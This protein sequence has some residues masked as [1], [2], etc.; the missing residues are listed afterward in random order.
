MQHHT[1]RLEGRKSFGSSFTA[2]PQH[3]LTVPVNSK[4]NILIDKSGRA[5]LTDFGLTS[6]TRGDNSTRSPQDPAI[7]STATWAAPEILQGGTET[8]EGDV[9]TFAMVTIEV[10]AR[11][12]FLFLYSMSISQYTSPS[13]QTFTGHTP[14][15]TNYQSALYEI[16]DGKRPGRPKKLKHDGLWKLIQRCWNQ[17]SRKRPNSS[18]IRDFF[19]AL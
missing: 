15:A 16:M 14:F 11:E 9:F 7:P 10:C 18:E 12:E 5:R 13:N 1:R 6:I 2:F 8:K 19:K 4:A 17:D 3:Q